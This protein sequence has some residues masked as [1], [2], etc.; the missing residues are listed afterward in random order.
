MSIWNKKKTDGQ[1]PLP[2]NEEQL[3]S[4]SAR[5]RKMK[6]GAY[7]TVITCVFVAVVILFNIVAT[8]LAERFPLSLDLTAGGD[9]T[10]NEENADYIAGIQRDDLNITIVVCADETAYTGGTF[11]V[12]YYDPSNGQYF[13]QNAYLLKEYT[14]RNKAIHLQYIDKSDP[15]FNAYTA[16]CPDEEFVDGDLLLIAEFTMDGE[17]VQR[18]RHLEL[19][20]L[21]EISY[22]QND[23]KSLYYAQYYYMMTL[24]SNNIETQVT[25]ALASLTSDKVYQ[26][27]VL[28]HNGGEEPT[29]LESLMKQNNYQFTEVSNLNEEEIPADADI[30]IVSRPMYDYSENELDLLDAFLDNDGQYGKTVFY[31][32]DAS[33]PD[34]PNLNEFLSEWGFSVMSG[35]WAVETDTDNQMNLGNLPLFKVSEETNTYTGELADSGYTFYS[36]YDVP[37]QLKKPNGTR[38]NQTLIAYADTA[39]SMPVD[40]QSLEEANGN[41]P[42]VALGLSQVTPAVLEDPTDIT[43]S[44]VVVCSSMEF[45]DL[46][47]YSAKIGN[48]YAIMN[49]LDTVMGKEDSG[50]SFDSRTYSNDQF[51][52]LPSSRAVTIVTAVLVILT[53]GSLVI[54]GVVIRRRRK[55]K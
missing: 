34:L 5:K 29:E 27:A 6:Y 51:E 4:R 55:R 1:E 45:I 17:K 32:A 24:M 8:I 50:V 13:V 42:F 40:G 52:E 36:T 23:Q 9:F 41:G 48:L 49:T 43:R 14:R 37:I 21:F 11:S 47:S 54:V 46:G 18:W 39:V 16:M 30:V 38:E 15:E 7:A 33:Q 2:V 35:N 31:I 26:V 19:E 28:T 3:R 53:V 12:N 10:I 20:D 25:S 22:D 44:Y